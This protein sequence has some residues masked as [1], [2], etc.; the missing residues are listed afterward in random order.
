MGELLESAALLALEYMYSNNPRDSKL[1]ISGHER[2]KMYRLLMGS[3]IFELKD[4][5]HDCL[6]FIET[7]LDAALF[8]NG[9]AAEREECLLS[10]CK[11]TKSLWN[12][13]GAID[14][15]KA[16]LTYMTNL[17]MNGLAYMTLRRCDFPGY[18][19][20]I[21]I[22]SDE[23]FERL[24][25]NQVGLDRILHLVSMTGS[26]GQL[27]VAGSELLNDWSAI[28][29]G[30]SLFENHRREYERFKAIVRW[31]ECRW[32]SRYPKHSFGEAVVKKSGPTE[33]PEEYAARL[34][35]AERILELL[36]ENCHVDLESFSEQ[37]NFPLSK[38]TYKELMRRRAT[39]KCRTYLP[40]LEDSCA[41][42][43]VGDSAFKLVYDP[44]GLLKIRRLLVPSRDIYRPPG[45]MDTTDVAS[46]LN[47]SEKADRNLFK[48]GLQA[49]MNGS[50]SSSLMVKALTI[51]TGK[52]IKLRV[53]HSATCIVAYISK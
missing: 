51:E 53:P 12:T 21:A 22:L 15:L 23:E 25:R 2:S 39:D 52:L 49:V 9:A 33:N 27:S 20:F 14:E 40:T 4:L 42:V 36:V 44:R 7:E 46:S 48:F 19:D 47:E 50:S 37:D 17:Y 43:S 16:P 5:T 35:F 45:K 29:T 13:F 10:L 18:R 26:R 30:D 32:K 28:F 8:A 3:L 11:F 1:F 38:S 41:F 6:D 31:C 34:A 24:L